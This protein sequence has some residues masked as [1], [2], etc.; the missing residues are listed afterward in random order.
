M[1]RRNLELVE[2]LRP[3]LAARGARAATLI[4]VLDETLTRMGARLLRQWLLRPLVQSEPIW[5]RQEAVAELLRSSAFATRA[6]RGAEADS[7]SGA[8]GRQGCQRRILPRE[9]RALGH[10]LRA[11]ARAARGI[12]P[13]Q[14]ALLQAIAHELDA[15]DDVRALIARAHRG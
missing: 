2:P 3:D 14:R 11:S 15:L 9:L 10:S 4:E 7:R 12:E 8:S 13:V 6:P 1:T 5:A